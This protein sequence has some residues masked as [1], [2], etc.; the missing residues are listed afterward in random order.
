MTKVMKID[1][2]IWNQIN[3]PAV[4]KAFDEGMKR[5]LKRVG[6]YHRTLAKQKWNAFAA[7]QAPMIGEGI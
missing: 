6:D 1:R 7:K 4:R 3:T 2:T 5:A